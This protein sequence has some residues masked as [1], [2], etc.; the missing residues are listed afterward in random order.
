MTFDEDPVAR[1]SFE[2]SGEKMKNKHSEDAG[3]DRPLD[4]GFLG[5]PQP[6]HHSAA[7]FSVIW[8]NN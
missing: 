5:E 8:L 1:W 7:D 4:S 2:L 6:P 3:P